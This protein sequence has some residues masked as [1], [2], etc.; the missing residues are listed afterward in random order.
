V[1]QTLAVRQLMLWLLSFFALSALLLA[2][3]G[4]YSVVAY[5]VGQRTREFGIRAALGAT[6]GN[7]VKLVLRRGLLLALGGLAIGVVAALNLTRLLGQLLYGINP[8]DP[9]TFA[10]VALLLLAVA[11]VA[12]WLPARRAANVDP[13]VALRAD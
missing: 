11:L 3:I 8:G 13:L 2:G 1:D 12:S 4:L 10:A 6:P 7:L 5:A 9:L